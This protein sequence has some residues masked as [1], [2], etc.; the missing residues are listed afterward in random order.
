MSQ[1][2]ALMLQMF[3]AHG[4]D[5]APQGEWV[6]FPNR[7][8]R[9]N[10]SIVKEWTEQ[11]PMSIQLDV[12]IA[13]EPWRTI[14]E[15]FA[16]VGETKE[17]TLRDALQNFAV[18]SFH[19]ILAAFFQSNDDQTAQE[20][21]TIG[22]TKRLVTLG[23]IGIRGAFPV[24][25]DQAVAWFRRFEEKLHSSQV[26]Q[27]THWV[28]LYYGQ[29]NGKA[30]ACEVLLDNQVWEAM[31]SE[32][33][34]ISWPGG[35]RFYSVRIFLVIQDGCQEIRE[36]ERNV[37][38]TVAVMAAHPGASDQEIVQHLVAQGLNELRAEMMASFVPL[39]LGRALIARLGANPPVT[40]AEHALVQDLEN[41]VV[42]EIPLAAVAEYV[43]AR[44][45]GEEA[46]VTGIIPRGPFRAASCRSS[47]LNALNKA[48]NA[49]KSLDGGRIEAP[50]LPRLGGTAGFNDW[51]CTLRP[52]AE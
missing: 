18:S 50:L 38:A 28:R 25:G 42:Q 45:L 41:G 40:M 26:G 3:Q 9:A 4:I 15:S 14:I 47:E 39:G 46:F 32:M 34:A 11:T 16:G 35:E 36:A 6:V 21:W 23:N 12:R 49:G 17:Q 27:G 5:A 29:A 19:V 8:L 31:Q 10:G 20:E 52:L 22:G 24:Q 30:I 2:N 1:I 48:L 37:L 44:R 43:A 33:A 7:N 13:I 51:Y